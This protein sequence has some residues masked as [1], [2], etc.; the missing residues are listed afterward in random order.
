MSSPT[1]SRGALRFYVGFLIAALLIAGGLSY[2]ASGDP[3]GLDKATLDGCEV[4]ETAA[5]EEL[6]GECIAQ[7][8]EEHPLGESPLADYTVNRGDGTV[9]VAGVIGVLVT[10]ALAG[11]LFWVL[12]RRTPSGK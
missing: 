6:T 11:G 7:N 1:Q 12:R 2:F 10:L 4:V 9:G 8:A 3:D 5:G